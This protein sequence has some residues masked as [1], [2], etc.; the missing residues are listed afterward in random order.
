MGLKLDKL[1][2]GQ[3]AFR[4]H[5]VPVVFVVGFTLAVQVLMIW[6]HGRSVCVES[7]LENILGD[8]TSWAITLGFFIWAWL[9]IKISPSVYLGPETA[10]GFKPRYAVNLTSLYY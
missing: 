10:F 5:V 1:V 3:N 4:Y 8:K 2:Y 7:V 9:S 6:A